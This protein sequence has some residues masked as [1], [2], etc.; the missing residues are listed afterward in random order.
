MLTVDEARSA[1]LDRAA[2]LPARRTRLAEALGLT[3]AED[4]AADIDLPPFDKAL[5]DGYAVRAAELAALGGRLTLGEEIPAGQAPSRPLG[6]GEAAAIMTGAPLPEGADAVVM[7]ER[8]RRD[9]QVVVVDGPDAKPGQN[10]LSRGRELRQG[11][12]V[13]RLG[14]RLNPVRLGLLASVGRSEVLVHP[15]PRVAVVPTGDELVEPGQVPGPAQIR[16]S[17]A[18]VLAALASVCQTEAESFPIARDEPET[19]RQ[20][21]AR[22]LDYD[23]LAITGGVSAGN[24]DLVPETLERLGVARVFHKLRLK[25]GKPLWFG[26]GPARGDRPGALVFGLPGNPVSGVVGFLLFVRPA[27]AALAGRPELAPRITRHALAR[28]FAQRGDRAAYHPARLAGPEGDQTVDPLDWAG[29]A[30][31]RSVAAAD[32]FAAFAPGDRVYQPGEVVDFLHL[33]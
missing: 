7:I 12:V 25:P 17:N 24:R 19:L 4:V 20:A 11:D 16:N 30:D 22:G 8:T 9:G 32:G 31:L 26:V 10:R 15:R 2:L 14:E 3:L 28:P 27:L 21:L 1:V 5:V 18:T 23:V 29:S 33:D 6:P 13:L